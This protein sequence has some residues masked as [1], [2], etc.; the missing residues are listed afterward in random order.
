MKLRDYLKSKNLTQGDFAEMVG[1]TRISVLRW[2][3]DEAIPKK[4]WMLAIHE[5]TKGKVRPHDFYF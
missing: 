4:E 5:A 1:C 2:V 3:H